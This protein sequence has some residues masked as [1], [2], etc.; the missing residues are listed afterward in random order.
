MHWDVDLAT[1]EPSALIRAGA[2]LL[3]EPDDAVSWWVL[4]DPEGNEF[5]AFPPRD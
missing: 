5:C 1:A 3:R 2:T 4:A